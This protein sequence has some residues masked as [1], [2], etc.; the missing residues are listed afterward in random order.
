MSS[1]ALRKLHGKGDKQ[2]DLPVGLDLEAD[3]NEVDSIAP[4]PSKS[5]KKKKNKKKDLPVNPF[6]LVG[7]INQHSK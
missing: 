2:L 3:E 1:R 7:T 6:D 5:N 4:Q